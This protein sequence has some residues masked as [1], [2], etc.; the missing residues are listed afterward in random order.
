MAEVI[1]YTNDSGSLLPNQV[2]TRHYFSNVNNTIAEK[3]NHVKELQLAGQYAEAANYIESQGLQQYILSADYI[4][5]IDEET[6][7]L[8]IMIKS[9]QQSIYY[10]ADEPGYATNG[11][12]WIGG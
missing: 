10:S 6:R 12:V 7:N 8:E 2:M 5:F 9:K 3:V 4:N 1:N 11:D